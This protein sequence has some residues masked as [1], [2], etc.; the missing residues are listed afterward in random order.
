MEVSRTAKHESAERNRARLRR[1]VPLVCAIV[2]L[3]YLG[4]FV[5]AIPFHTKHMH[6]VCASMLCEGTQ[7]KQDMLTGLRQIGMSYR[8]YMGYSL[9]LQI[10]FVCIFS[11]VACF[12]FCIKSREWMALV[13]ALFLVTFA[14]N[15]TDAPR[16]LEQE[17]SAWWLPIAFLGA[18]GE[19]FFPLCFYL[20]PTGHFAP[21]W[22]RW[23][24]IGW[25]VWGVTTYFFPSGAFHE[26]VW[27]LTLEAV[28]FVVA[29]CTLLV[30]QVYRFYYISNPIQCQQT[31]WAVFG[32]AL[33]IVGFLAA[34]VLGFFVPVMLNTLFHWQVSLTLFGI[35]GLTMSYVIPLII[36]LAIGTALLRFHLW[37]V[38]TLIKRTL[39]YSLL[40][41]S[42]VIVYVL[43]ILVLQFA[44]QGLMGRTD[45]SIVVSTLAIAALFHPL[46]RQ[47]QQVI[48]RRFYRRRYDAQQA[49]ANFHRTLQ[50]EIELIQLREQLA[51][52]VDEMMQPTFIWL[53]LRKPER[54]QAESDA[55]RTVSAARK[56]RRLLLDT[57]DVPRNLS[58][59]LE[60]ENARR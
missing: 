57:Q 5:L 15:V 43:C 22:T 34:G 51:S 44:L 26:S 13:V 16:I 35:I 29:V 38:D 24:L 46:R 59:R 8:F 20:F 48:D 9:T 47:L 10:L 18:V 25:G 60:E 11:A 23:L 40:T 33:G 27:Y 36:P 41:I 3:L 52:L 30:S 1:L 14:V 58:E 2:G 50:G 55:V 31:K 4:L 21:R 37:D 6:T 28:L 32:F 42:L 49:I 45:L 53:W 17:Y 19:L 12:I 56:T 7:S 54:P 39:V